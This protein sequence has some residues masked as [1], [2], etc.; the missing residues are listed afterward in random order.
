VID[1]AVLVDADR[2]R[3]AAEL[4]PYRAAVRNAPSLPARIA[5]ARKLR[6]AEA[7]VN[8]ARHALGEPWEREGHRA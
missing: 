4:A 1:L 3:R 7:W 6:A 8:S 2:A 5:A